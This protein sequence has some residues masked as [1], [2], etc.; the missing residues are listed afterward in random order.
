MDYIALK[1][2]IKIA[3]EIQ[4]QWKDGESTGTAEI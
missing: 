2:K 3:F 1:R 4:Y